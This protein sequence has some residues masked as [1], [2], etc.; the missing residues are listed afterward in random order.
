MFGWSLGQENAKCGI[1][2]PIFK[3]EATCFEQQWSPLLLKL[4]DIWMPS[5]ASKQ[6]TSYT[7]NLQQLFWINF[8][9][10][11]KFHRAR[12]NEFKKLGS[13]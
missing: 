3:S 12:L 6:P 2:K 9:P 5:V 8:T 11:K 10:E 7:T 13:L 4:G 1:K